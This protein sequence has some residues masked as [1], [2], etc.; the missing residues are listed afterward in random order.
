[1]AQFHN[2]MRLDISPE[3]AWAVVGDLAGVDTWIPGVT[4]VKIPDSLGAQPITVSLPTSVQ[5]QY[6][7]NG[8]TATLVQ[9]P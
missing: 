2:E 4:D 5:A 8:Y 1:M 9:K 7:G 6:S 3:I